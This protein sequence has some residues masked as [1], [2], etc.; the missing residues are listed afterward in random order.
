MTGSGAVSGSSG[1][2][3]S[4]TCAFV[5]LTPNA[6]TAALRARSTTGHA[7]ARVNTSTAPADQSTCDD[8][9][10]TCNVLGSTP[11]R[12]AITILITPATPAAACV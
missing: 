2:C 10:S 8:G 5:P 6:D 3:S 9:T 1:A 4:T 11:C 12:N 7:R